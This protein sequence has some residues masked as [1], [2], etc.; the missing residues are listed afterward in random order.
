MKDKYVKTYESYKKMSEI[1]SINDGKIIVPIYIYSLDNELQKLVKEFSKKVNGH[2]SEPFYWI[3]VR[4]INRLYNHPKFKYISSW[5]DVMGLL[6]E[7]LKTKMENEG[8]ID[9]YCKPQVDRFIKEFFKYMPFID[10]KTEGMEFTG[11]A[12]GYCCGDCDGDEEQ[13]IRY[14]FDRDLNGFM[15]RLSEKYD[16]K[17]NFK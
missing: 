11:L 5:N 14:N 1:D 16:I 8:Y 9:E 2:V 12:D 7:F 15:S 10:I 6:S 13:Y 4:D 17:I 3:S